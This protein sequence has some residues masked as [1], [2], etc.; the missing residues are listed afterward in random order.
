VKVDIEVA[1]A[2][3]TSVRAQQVSAMFDVPPRDRDALRWQGEIPIESRDWT[4]GLIV[5]PSGSGKTTILRE[6][7]GAPLEFE[8]QGAS[9]LDDFATDIA[10]SDITDACS[11][12]GFNTIPAWL[13]PHAV[14]ST[15]EQF[16]VSLARA[17]LETPAESPV[18]IDEFT[19]VVDRQVA[20]I[21]AHAAQKY[22][23]KAKRRLVVATCHFDVIEWLQP[24]WVFEPATV[25]FAWGCERPRPQLECEIRRVH[26][27][28]W[29]RYAPFHYL[30]ADLTHTAACYELTVE[31]TPAAFNAVIHR[32]QPQVRNLKGISRL[33]CLPDWQGL[34][35]GPALSEHVA[36]AYTALGF[37]VHSVLAHPHLIRVRDKSPTWALIHRGGMSSSYRPKG[38]SLAGGENLLKAGRRPTATFRY[39]GPPLELEEAR[40]L[41]HSEPQAPTRPRRPRQIGSRQRAA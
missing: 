4:V 27:D 29:K 22:V 34:G 5:G 12:V 6:C 39:V 10:I 35:I 16:R 23:R 1:T 26:R 37:R 17:L 14:L 38:V 41:V 31:G 11:A 3:S 13:R 18:L 9:V 24:D 32:P 19:S 20:K 40:A 30:T 8:W 21:G 36:A 2:L 28:R 25:D 15:G 33:V 7:F